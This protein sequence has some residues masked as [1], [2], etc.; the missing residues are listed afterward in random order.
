MIDRDA[1]LRSIRS[2][3]GSLQD[4]FAEFADNIPFIERF[5]KCDEEQWLTMR[6]HYLASLAFVDEQIGRLQQHLIAT[7]LADDTLIIFSADHG[8]MLGDHNY[9]TKGAWHFDACARVPL[10]IAGPGVQPGKRNEMVS[11]LDLFP[12]IVDYAGAESTAPVEGD[13]LRPLLENSGSL[14]RPDA[15]IVESYGNIE[16]ALTAK[17]L[18]TQASHYY[19]LGDGQ[20]LLFDRTND[21]A[22]STNLASDAS[23]KPRKDKL[24][25]LMLEMLSRQNMPLPLRN[26]HPFAAH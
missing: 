21:P 1:I 10:L 15:V 5:A 9:P 2:V 4:I 13:S 20:K 6:H 26:R 3:D 12:T 11:L 18:I 23:E 25:K 7:G 24:R 22:E 19:R 8:D 14:P 17:S 16:P